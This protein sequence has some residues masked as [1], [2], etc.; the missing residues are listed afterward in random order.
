M[1]AE[2]SSAELDRRLKKAIQTS[3][4][5]LVA[6]LRKPT[7]TDAPPVFG[8]NLFRPSLAGASQGQNGH[9][10]QGQ[11][12]HEGQGHDGDEGQG[13]GDKDERGKV[14]QSEDDAMMEEWTTE[15]GTTALQLAARYRSID[16]V[17]E[18]KKEGEEKER[19][20]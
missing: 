1:T 11:G 7:T 2:D 12:R 10:G 13:E 5:Q 18:R 4:T 9:K 15:D 17:K 16:G 8:K 19:R 3:M 6:S 14:T 20:E